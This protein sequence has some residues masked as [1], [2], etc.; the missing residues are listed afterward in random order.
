MIRMEF[1]HGG[2][3]GVFPEWW[4]EASEPVVAG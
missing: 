3:T 4:R 2:Y 1:L